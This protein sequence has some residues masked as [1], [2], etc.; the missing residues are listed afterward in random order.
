MA[1]LMAAIAE[2]ES[3]GN[4]NATGGVGEKGLW[5]I[6]PA[7]WGNLATY[8]PLGNA[9]AAVHVLQVQGLGAWSTYN[10]GDYRRYLQGNV[11]PG[12]GTLP[13]GGSGSG[14][15]SGGGGSGGNATLT[16]ANPNI[17]NSFANGFLGQL[18]GL[19]PQLQ[20]DPLQSLV[21]LTDDVAQFFKWISWMF[22]PAHWL[23]IGAFFVGVISLAGAGYMFKEAL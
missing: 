15:G 12:T 21:A 1:P 3:S 18:F 6:N 22:D 7:A 16:S 4:S 5:Q 13:G 14:G 23:R 2:A 11:P 20:A 10:H 8:D 19:P 9:R 17:F